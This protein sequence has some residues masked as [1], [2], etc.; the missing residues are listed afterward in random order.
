M[1]IKNTNKQESLKLLNDVIIPYVEMER[2]KLELATQAALITMD[3][4]KGKI[5][6]LALKKV[7]WNNI[8]L[9]KVPPNLSHIYQPLNVT[10]NGSAK[11]T[12]SEK[13]P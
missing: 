3:V 9:L 2:G 5:T 4:F 10:V 8:Q 11:D 12:H 7:S 6:T 13:A 1:P